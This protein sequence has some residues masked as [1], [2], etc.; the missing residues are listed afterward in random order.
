MSDP[1]MPKAKGLDTKKLKGRDIAALLICAAVILY[2]TH[3]DLWDRP[4]RPSESASSAPTPP[5]GEKSQSTATSAGPSVWRRTLT[6][7]PFESSKKTL[8]YAA[9]SEGNNSFLILLCKGG[10]L[11][12][13]WQ[14]SESGRAPVVGMQMELMIRFDDLPPFKEEWTWSADSPILSPVGRDRKF[15]DQMNGK[16]KL[17]IKSTVAEGTI[18]VFN[19]TGFDQAYSEAR[20][21][22]KA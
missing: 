21:L 18:G 2:F 17:A 22:C 5:Q 4:S 20:Q 12:F 7:D 11:Q 16:R 1:E 19:I 15:L 3:G 9:T 8:K 13:A 6:E 10:A 14:Y